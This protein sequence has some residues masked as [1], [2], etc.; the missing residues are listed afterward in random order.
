M[1]DPSLGCIIRC[2]QLWDVDDVPTHASGSNEASVGEVLKLLAMHVCF[3]QL[4]A[5]P[6]CTGSLGTV[7]SAIEIG[8]N[9]L[10][11]MIDLSVEHCSLRPW[12]TGI[13]DEDVET[14]IEFLDNLV[15]RLLDML[16]VC[17]VDLV[18]LA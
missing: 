5:S 18:C 4:L 17:D 1:D 14:A 11:V 16:G 7:V 9:D 6:M 10:A 13:G 3:L 2:L 12:D 15:D 8:G